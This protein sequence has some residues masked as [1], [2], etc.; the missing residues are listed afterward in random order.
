M[1]TLQL[2]FWILQ[3]CRINTIFRSP[4]RWISANPWPY[5]CGRRDSRPSLQSIYTIQSTRRD[6]RYQQTSGTH[7]NVFT[8]IFTRAA[9]VEDTHTRAHIIYTYIYC[10]KICLKIN[11]L[12]A[13]RRRRRENE[14]HASSAN[15]RHPKTYYCPGEVRD[16]VSPRG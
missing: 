6:D 9:V 12:Y 3:N 10:D 11:R 2:E 7:R 15:G 14:F 13:K 8:R 5:V 1:K 16:P 4:R